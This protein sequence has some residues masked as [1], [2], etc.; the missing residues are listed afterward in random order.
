MTDVA[1]KQSEIQANE[2]SATDRFLAGLGIRPVEKSLV[3]LLFGNMFLS[4]LATGIIR[5]CA[6]TL[7]L[8][9]FGSEQLALVAILLAFTGTIVTLIIDG[10]THQFSTRGYLFTVLGTIL[11]GILIIRLLLDTIDSEILIFLLP[12]FFEVVYMLFSLQFVVLLTRLLNVRQTKRLSALARSGEF[13]AELVGGLSIAVLLNYM[14]VPDLLLV[15]AIAVIAL[16]AIV[17]FTIRKFTSKLTLESEHE[18][19]DEVQGNRMI[20]MLRIPYVRMIAF[21]YATYI[22]AY[23]FLDVAFY[24]YAAV[25]F[26]DNR[27]LATFIGQFFAVSGFLTML[28]M[29]FIFAPFIRRFGMLAGVI[30]FPIVIAL[31]SIAVSTMEFSAVDAGLIFLVMVG[32]NGLRFI[33]QSAIWKPSVGVLFQVLPD[34]QRARGTSLIEGIVDPISGGIAGLCLYILSEFLD[35][36]PEL[37]LLALAGLMLAWIVIGFFI[38][39]QYL[40]NLVLSIQKRK[41][42]ELSV[43]QL[44]NASMKIIMGGLNSPYPAE[45]FYCLNILEQMEHPDLTNHLQYIIANK[46][47]EVRMNILRRIER[48]RTSKLAPQVLQRIRAEKNPLV[49]GQAIRTYASL[50]QDDTLEHLIPLLSSEVDDIRKGALVGILNYDPANDQALTYLLKLVRSETVSERLFAAD[51]LGEIASDVFSGFLVELLDDADPEV[52]DNAVVAAGQIR[53]VRLVSV[54]VDKLRSPG[55]RG[56]A[57]SALQKFGNDAL[58]ELDIAFTSPTATRQVKHKILEIICELGT[59]D[60]LRTLLQYIDIDLPELRHQIY[61]GLAGLHY[62]A[63]ADD[64]YLFV[65]MIDNE[66]ENITWL[67]ATMKDLESAPGFEQVHSAMGYEL[68]VHRDNMLL[69]TSFI[70]SSIVMLDTR[71]N[72]DSKVADLRVFALEVLDVVLTAEIK[73]VVI[74]LLDDLTVTEQLAHL[75]VRFPQRSMSAEDRFDEIVNDHFETA[76]YWTRSSLLYLIGQMGKQAHR[77]V[78]ES[79][80]EDREPIVRETALWALTQLQPPG[81]RQILDE[82]IDDDDND[83]RNIVEQLI[84][85]L[86][87]PTQ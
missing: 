24:K 14:D 53:D 79:C 17:Q 65:N 18:T 39:H 68:E 56:R 6:F 84:S 60:A 63:D 1:Y 61:I 83:V 23:F 44:D 34:K 3:A 26:P 22:F 48:L 57:G 28:A 47:E 62:Q 49:L 70:F 10:I 31:G 86:A 71:A 81:I 73:E 40:A 50:M 75:S 64:H 30:A 29:V 37:F 58:D 42:G 74:P 54:L 55:L 32:T 27:E 69:L 76:F 5:V 12:L 13:L 85:Q 72:I 11:S 19:T 35:W 15:A 36:G 45:I 7:F 51:V 43:A 25:E 38:R 87:E 41:L 4:G 80:L 67:L 21:C 33:L 20:S 52:I 78:V 66:V 8:Q 46:N 2:L 82:H 77:H 59:P 9:Y 16:F